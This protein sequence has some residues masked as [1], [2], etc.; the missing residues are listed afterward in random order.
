MHIIPLEK[1]VTWKASV[2]RIAEGDAPPIQLASFAHSTFNGMMLARERLMKTRPSFKPK[3]TR[4]GQAR[5]FALTL[6]N[7]DRPLAEIEDSLFAEYPDLFRRRDQAS[8]F[9]SELVT[10]HTE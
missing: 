2:T 4:R 6:C 7:G 3:L 5:A 10:H 9:V 8:A 1:M